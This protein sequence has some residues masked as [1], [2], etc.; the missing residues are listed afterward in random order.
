[1]GKVV[2]WV[3]DFADFQVGF[4]APCLLPG[5]RAK[6]NRLGIANCVCC[7]IRQVEFPRARDFAGWKLHF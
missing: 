6:N 3:N 7:I 5:G 1:M 2:G 4:F